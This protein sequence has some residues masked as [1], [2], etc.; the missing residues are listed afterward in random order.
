[1]KNPLRG[2]KILTSCLN[3]DSLMLIGLYSEKARQHI[4][5]I[6]DKIDKLRL[7]SSYSNIVK[8]RKDLIEHNN[9]K[10]NDIKSSPDFYTLSGVRDLLF[11][12]QEHRFTISKIKKNLDK[13]GLF[14]LGFD[15]KLVIENFMK[16]Y[17]KK[18]DLYDLDKWQE[19]ENY[20][21]RI[22]ASMYQ[23]WCKKL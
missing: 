16:I 1:M 18:S 22:F 12:V 2:W 15:D 7:H 3:N 8:F 11:H 14:F 19:Y 23:F 17:N 4:T 20:N 13:L 5:Y 10:W 21:P 6:K 9:D